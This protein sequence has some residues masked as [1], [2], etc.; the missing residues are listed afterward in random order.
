M[1]QIKIMGNYF[2]FNNIAFAMLLSVFILGSCN[3]EKD[4][5]EP[6]TDIY[7]EDTSFKVV[8]YL[9]PSAFSKIDRMDLSKT[10]YINLSFANLDSNGEMVFNNGADYT[11]VV[12]KLKAKDIKVLM[13][14]GGGG[15]S[16]T[17]AGYWNTHLVSGKRDKTIS[18]IVKYVE[19]NNLDGIDVDFEGSVLKGLGNYYNLFVQELKFALHANGKT[20]TA[21]LPFGFLHGNVT[22]ATLNAFDFINVMAYDV[23]GPWS[24]DS[25]GQHAP[26][27]IVTTIKNFW[28]INKGIPEKKIVLGV[29]FYGY[30]FERIDEYEWGITWAQI[31]AE[32]L[33][34]AYVDEVH[35]SGKKMYYNGIPT[36]ASKTQE[37]LQELGGVMNWSLGIDSFDDMSLLKTINQVVDAGPGNGQTITTYFADED[38]D[39]LGSLYKPFQAYEQP[40]GYVTNRND[41]DDSIAN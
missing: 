2:S 31:I 38:G 21:A 34:Y 40:E 36:I 30:D 35:E 18:G 26:S 32:D 17:I 11:S 29:P 33:Q 10:T 3:K 14:L 1:K 7:E 16:S 5:I 19:D 25:P 22:T 37:A 23:T 27:N 24:P 28:L 6:A 13:S 39:G 9:R 20:I 8:G 15:V 41:S 12:S 4:E